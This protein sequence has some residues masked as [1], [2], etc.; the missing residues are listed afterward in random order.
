MIDVLRFLARIAILHLWILIDCPTPSIFLK[1]Q[2]LCGHYFSLLEDL[3]HVLD[4]TGALLPD[5]DVVQQ[6]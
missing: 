4:V 3:H 6:L 1:T 2:D 5:R